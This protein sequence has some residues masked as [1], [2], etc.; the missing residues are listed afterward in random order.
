MMLTAKQ[1]VKNK[2]WIL[3]KDGEKIATIQMTEN[4]NVVLVSKNQEREQFTDIK[5]LKKKY[6]INFES[7]KPKKEPASKEF[8]VYGF[9]SQFK[10][11]N[12]LLDVS[13][14]VPI[15]TKTEKSKSFYCAGY[16]IIKFSGNFVGA[17][18]PK[19]I[20][21]N[22]YEFRGPYCNKAEMKEQLKIANE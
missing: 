10:P 3:E 11:H 1:I 6:N 9:P 22:R 14:K 21:L 4:G 18:C 12:Q 7:T 19:L 13:K 8:A 16:Y 5:L 15:F 2:F 20:T 17:Y